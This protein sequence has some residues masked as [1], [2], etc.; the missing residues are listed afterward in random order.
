M[1][2][3]WLYHVWVFSCSAAAL[4]PQ[5]IQLSGL[6]HFLALLGEHLAFLLQVAAFLEKSTN[7]HAQ[8]DTRKS[9]HSTSVTP[10]ELTFDKKW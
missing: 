1:A 7:Q 10:R 6:F 4:F 2:Y 9:L 5:T 3:H 8:S